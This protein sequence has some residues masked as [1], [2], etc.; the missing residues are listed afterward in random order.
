MMGNMNSIIVL[1]NFGKE[2]LGVQNYL[3]CTYEYLGLSTKIKGIVISMNR[4]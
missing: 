1:R 2:F 4:L 3:K